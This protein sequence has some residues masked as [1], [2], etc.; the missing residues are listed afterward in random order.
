MWNANN[1]WS[2]IGWNRARSSGFVSFKSFG[3]RLDVCFNWF[4][5]LL[6]TA[7]DSTLIS[8]NQSLF[9]KKPIKNRLR[10][11]KTSVGANL[12]FL[13]KNFRV[14]LMVKKEPERYWNC[15]STRSS[16]SGG[17][18]S[19][20]QMLKDNK[21]TTFTLFYLFLQTTH[22]T[23]KWPTFPAGATNHEKKL[24]KDAFLVYLVNAKR[25]LIHQRQKRLPLQLYK[26]VCDERKKRSA[27]PK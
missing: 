18:P 24:A 6:F 25:L 7:K 22:S 12:I 1:L 19:P 26:I 2:L 16:W 5:F 15:L 8:M 9:G 11:F 27:K 13:K 3:N 20:H 4:I 14:P 10:S 23:Q 17:P 21:V